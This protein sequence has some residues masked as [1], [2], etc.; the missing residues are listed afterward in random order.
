LQRADE[1]RMTFVLKRWRWRLSP[2]ARHARKM[3]AQR[4]A[5]LSHPKRSAC[6]R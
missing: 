2:A 4:V 1:Q 3:H 5:E 6:T